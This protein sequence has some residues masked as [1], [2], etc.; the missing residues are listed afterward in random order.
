[1]GNDPEPVPTSS[2]TK[3]ARF[4]V[5]VNRVW[6]DA[7]G[8]QQEETDW[9]EIITWGS[10]AENCL[11]YLTKGQL[12]FVTGRPQMRQWEDEQ[13]QKRKRFQVSAGQVIFLNRP[14][15]EGAIE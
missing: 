5:A 8:Q 4:S 13:G 10:L 12:V 1:V 2:G 7:S 11:A 3:G 15:S 14:K 6:T 9:F